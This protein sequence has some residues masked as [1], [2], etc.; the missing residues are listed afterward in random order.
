M[1]LLV[2]YRPSLSSNVSTFASHLSVSSQRLQEVPNVASRG[3]K[4]MRYDSNKS[5]SRLIL[6]R[7]VFRGE[8]GEISF[9]MS[10]CARASFKRVRGQF[11]ESA[12]F[13]E[14]NFMNVRPTV[15][16]SSSFVP[17]LSDPREIPRG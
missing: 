2:V 1:L 12:V 4:V 5:L 13:G 11:R 7:R 8:F 6:A 3:E 9:E 15:V 14:E 10:L 17:Y 16:D